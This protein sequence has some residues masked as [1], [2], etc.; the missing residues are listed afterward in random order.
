MIDGCTAE[1]NG[2]AV[3][4]E[5]GNTFAI[6]G[7][8]TIRNNTI[9]GKVSD[10][11]GGAIYTVKGED[12][13]KIQGSPTFSGNTLTD[14]SYPGNPA[15]KNGGEEVYQD[16]KIRQD[17]YLAGTGNVLNMLDVTGKIESGEG[18]IWV[19]L[20]DEKHYKVQTQFAKF[21]DPVTGQVG[22]ALS[23]EEQESTMKAFRNARDDE[24][25]E[26]GTDS[27]LYGT[28]EGETEGYIYW[29]DS[30]GSRRV[31]LRKAD[32]GYGPLSG[33]SFTVYKGSATAAYTPKGETNVL[34]GLPS[35][36]NGVFWIGDLANG[37]YIIQKADPA[38]YF[39]LVVDDSGV[40]GNPDDA[41]PGYDFPETAREKGEEKYKELRQ[42]AKNAQTQT[43]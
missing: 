9:T 1:I 4:I 38:K 37:W 25:T 21:F 19:W 23:D 20:E 29:N 18:S 32:T 30:S 36:D 41:K 16:G 2:S 10:K 7:S 27:W 12:T 3:Y 14:S 31:I 11:K 34:S 40:Y 5:I 6:E 15:R 28:D 26:N 24:T 43:P 22:T 33:R 39:Y 13:L 35:W 17:I 8:P 42:A